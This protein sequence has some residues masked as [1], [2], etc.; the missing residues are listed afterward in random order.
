MIDGP[1][2]LVQ[3][4][5]EP[6][7]A[8]IAKIELS[9]YAANLLLRQDPV[10]IWAPKIAPNFWIWGCWNETQ[11]ATFCCIAERVPNSF[12]THSELILNALWTGTGSNEYV[13][14]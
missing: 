4:D 5:A 13:Y 12:W 6:W 8:S 14:A 3:N 11:N 10:A 9:S 1:S 2:M 7:N